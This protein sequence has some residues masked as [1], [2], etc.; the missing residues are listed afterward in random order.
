MTNRE[1]PSSSVTSVNG[2]STN[3]AWSPNLLE[4]GSSSIVAEFQ[5]AADNVHEE[6]AVNNAKI[7]T[8]NDVISSPL[9]TT[10]ADGEMNSNAGSVVD[11]ELP[12]AISYVLKVVPAKALQQDQQLKPCASYAAAVQSNQQRY[13]E[14]T[15]Q[16]Q[17]EQT[18]GLNRDITK[19][20]RN[21][22]EFVGVERNRMKTKAFFLS[23]IN[24]KVASKQ[25]LDYLCHRNIIPT[26]L[27][28]S[29]SKRKG[30]ISAK[31]NIKIKDLAGLSE[32]NF[33]PQFVRCRPWVSREKFSK[34]EGHR[35]QAT[36]SGKHS[37]CANDLDI[38]ATSRR[39]FGGIAFYWRKHLNMSIDVLSDLGNDRI[40]VLKKYQNALGTAL[41]NGPVFSS[42][43]NTPNAIEQLV[44]HTANLEIITISLLKTTKKA[45]YNFRK[46]Q[47]QAIHEDE[48]N[49][50][51]K[52]ERQH[53][54]E[55]SK[56]YN[57]I[58]K[59]KKPKRVNNGEVLEFDGNRVSNDSKV[60]DVWRQHYCNLY[61]LR[62]N[63]NVDN[64]FKKFV[65]NKHV[66][67]HTDSYRNDDPPFQFDEVVD[68]CCKLPNRMASG[69]DQL[70]Y[71]RVKFERNLLFE[72]L[73]KILNAVREL[74][75]VTDAWSI[76][77]IFFLFKGGKKNRF[78][79]L[80]KTIEP[81]NFVKCSRQNI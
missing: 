79:K 15:K 40:A 28:V 56:F 5:D 78:N 53:D 74:E 19:P 65:E 17:M 34:T 23:G 9:I 71:E 10:I 45:T 37:T 22:V 46:A 33:W 14:K 41:Q 26:L 3:K 51:V 52:L 64:D 60:L 80:K 69:P 62:D 73:T 54:I 68:V 47:R 18:T 16:Q 30:T 43:A 20:S 2:A 36:Q 58:T 35:I 48:V 70:S 49:G 72:V 1:E 42:E 31:L 12:G 55:R 44:D 59:L 67:F 21:T 57:R 6:M 25:I 77:N 76:G 24:D 39:G 32:P 66:Q 4:N 13:Q 11:L 61:T 75:Y 38:D 81:Y 29:P 27:N 8:N 7:T 63:P 50:F